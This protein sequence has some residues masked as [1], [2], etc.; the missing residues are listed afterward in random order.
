MTK[1]IFTKRNYL[2]F[3][4][5]AYTFLGCAFMVNGDITPGACCLL[6]A[7]Y[8]SQNVADLKA[9]NLGNSIFRCLAY[10]KKHEAE[11]GYKITVEVK[12][13]TNICINVEKTTSIVTFQD[14]QNN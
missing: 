1:K 7:L 8:V 5:F 9:K 13:E 3:E 11:T 2:L 10:K 14:Y 6:V 4:I 12:D